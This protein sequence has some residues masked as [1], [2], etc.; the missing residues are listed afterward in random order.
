[1][2]RML[3]L[4]QSRE[5]GQRRPAT[6]FAEA[7]ANLGDCHC[8]AERYQQARRNYRAALRV[9]PRNG[10][11][12]LKLAHA[13]EADPFGSDERA[14]DCY[15]RAIRF[16]SR[17]IHYAMLGRCA[18]RVHR[19]SLARKALLRAMALAPADGG[20]LAIVAEACREAGWRKLAWKWLNQARFLAPH[21]AAIRELWDRYCFDQAVVKKPLEEQ[22][23]TLPFLRIANS[24]WRTD[25]PAALRYPNL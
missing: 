15:R 12:W 19:V 17:A 8:H 13:W 16:E 22:R 20:V 3:S 18:L 6:S 7:I 14:L 5:P 24:T 25:G 21:S 2:S 9:E 10:A 11:L 4:Y 1:M 23:A